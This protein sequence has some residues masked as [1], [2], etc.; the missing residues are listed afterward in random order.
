MIRVIWSGLEEEEEEEVCMYIAYRY[1][2]AVYVCNRR[3]EVWWATGR[4]VDLYIF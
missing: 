3:N 4:T 1:M 2:Y